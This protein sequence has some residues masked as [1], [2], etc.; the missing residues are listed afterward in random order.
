VNVRPPTQNTKHLGSGAA[1][2]RASEKFDVRCSMFNVRCFAI[3]FCLL[4]LHSFAAPATNLLNAG[5]E[6]YRAGEFARAGQ[7]FQ[8]CL[9]TRPSSGAFQNL[10][11]AEWQLG[12]T[13]GAILAWERAL[14]MNPFDRNA[15]NNLRFA[16]DVAQLEAPELAWHEM[17]STWLPMN[18]WAWSAGVSLWLAVGMITLPGFLRWRKAPWQQ[19][20]AALALAVF[21]FTIPAHI[22][23][24]SRSRIGFVLAGNTPL[25]LTPTTEAEV[26]SQLN[27]G[28]PAREIRARGN[29]VFIR[30]TH[31]SG[32]IERDR[33]GLICSQ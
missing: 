19:A 20:I 7:C 14:W 12:R 23:T 9:T 3:W 5:V 26:L 24:L 13:G 17:A 4:A 22:G 16:R 2:A 32:W 33:F 27:A 30:T 21:L 8:S 29:Y 18:W 25:R 15:R 31:G 10:G 1:R 11:N 28:E 6:A